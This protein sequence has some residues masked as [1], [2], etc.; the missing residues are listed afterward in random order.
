MM[1]VYAFM[2]VCICANISKDALFHLIQVNNIGVID[3]KSA[4]IEASHIFFKWICITSQTG[5]KQ[6]QR[7]EP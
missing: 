7:K 4:L 6:Q 2:L 1:F 5:L 3:N